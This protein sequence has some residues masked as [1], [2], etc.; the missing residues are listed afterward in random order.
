MKWKIS[1]SVEWKDN[2][3]KYVKLSYTYSRIGAQ[4]GAEA[5]N[6]HMNM[7]TLSH[8]VLNNALHICERT[9]TL[10]Y[11]LK[12]WV[13]FHICIKNC[14]FFFSQLLICTFAN[15]LMHLHCASHNHISSLRTYLHYHSHTPWQIFECFTRSD[16]TYAH[17]WTYLHISHIYMWTNAFDHHTHVCNMKCNPHFYFCRCRGIHDDWKIKPQ[18]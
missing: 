11:Y 6:Q 15:I 13:C 4:A 8:F 3:I 18:K 10:T 1:L 14:I 16:F 7:L 5:N 12:S 2:H 17:L 9:H